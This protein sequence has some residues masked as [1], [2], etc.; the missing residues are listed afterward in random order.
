MYVLL[1]QHNPYCIKLTLHNVIALIDCLLY[2]ITYILYVSDHL[3]KWPLRYILS[4][5]LILGLG[6]NTVCAWTA[7]VSIWLFLEIY[8][9]LKFPVRYSVSSI[10][11]QRMVRMCPHCGSSGILCFVPHCL[12]EADIDALLER[13]SCLKSLMLQCLL[14]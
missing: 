13:H 10:A 9:F 7:V 8:F 3:P 2:M 11:K 6:F 4:K 5:F 12:L 14:L 1:E